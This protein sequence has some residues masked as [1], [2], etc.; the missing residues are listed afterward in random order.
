MAF[1]LFHVLYH[2]PFLLLHLLSQ[3]LVAPRSA[4]LRLPQL[5]LLELYLY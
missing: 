4:Q 1:P 2:Y 3:A 5:P